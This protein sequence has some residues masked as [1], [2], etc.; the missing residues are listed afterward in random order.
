MKQNQSTIIDLQK[1]VAEDSRSALDT[2]LREGAQRMLQ[3][4]VELEVAQYIDEY[5][6]ARD[7]TGLRLV[8]E[9]ANN[10]GTLFFRV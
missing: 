1:R 6:S 7:E 4:A 3:S 8:A 9:C 2:I 5:R 10:N